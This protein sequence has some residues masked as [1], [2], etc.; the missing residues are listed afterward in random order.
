MDF[1]V[2]QKP[3]SSDPQSPFQVYLLELN[4]EPAIELTGQRLRWILEELHNS[5]AEVCVAPFFKLKEVDLSH[6]TI[7][8]S[9]YGLIKCCEEQV[10]GTDTMK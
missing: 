2:V 3:Q 8:D 6:W 5:I 4:S 1:M 10:L 9:R 7:G